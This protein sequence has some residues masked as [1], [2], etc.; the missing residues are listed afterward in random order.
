MTGES[1]G[2]ETLDIGRCLQSVENLPIRSFRQ[3]CRLEYAKRGARQG[4]SPWRVRT[5]L[6]FTQVAL[7]RGCRL[8]LAGDN[9]GLLVFVLTAVGF[10]PSIGALVPAP[11]IPVLRVTRLQLAATFSGLP[12]FLPLVEARAV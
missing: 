4:A 2:V 9:G 11:R 8:Q 3:K 6:F 12:Q 1:V 5:R 7:L 10:N